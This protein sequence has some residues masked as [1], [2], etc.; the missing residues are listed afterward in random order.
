[1][2]HNGSEADF[3]LSIVPAKWMEVWSISSFTIVVFAAA[4]NG[5]NL[6][7]LL[8]YCC[9]FQFGP[10]RTLLLILYSHD[11]L[12]SCFFYPALINNLTYGNHGLWTNVELCQVFG[13]CNTFCSMF[14]SLTAA[15]IALYRAFVTSQK[16]YSS[17]VSDQKRK[18]A[19]KVMT[20]TSTIAALLVASLPFMVPEEG[21]IKPPYGFCGPNTHQYARGI[22]VV[23]MTLWVFI[24]ATICFLSFVKIYSD[25]K[26]QKNALAGPRPSPQL[27]DEAS[28][29]IHASFHCTARE[30]AVVLSVST[31]NRNYGRAE[32]RLRKL[33]KKMLAMFITM[34]VAHLPIALFYLCTVRQS[35]DP[36][37]NLAMLSLNFASMIFHPVGYFI[38]SQLT[39]YLFFSEFRRRLSK[40]EYLYMRF[41]VDFLCRLC[42]ERSILRCESHISAFLAF[43]MSEPDSRR[44]PRT[45]TELWSL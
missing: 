38:H 35:R 8:N 24:P 20:I 17:R 22:Q 11:L 18:T 30:A 1:M 37:L 34:L 2:Y 9:R 31:S 27:P 45:R 44:S 7:T 36:T 32:V 12:L 10:T 23:K 29:T 41:T 28:P 19:V 33:S 39:W 6:F 42:T 21:E 3:L 4:F 16:Y 43:F 15:Q 13:Y 14:S 40:S 26:K 25:L 5:F